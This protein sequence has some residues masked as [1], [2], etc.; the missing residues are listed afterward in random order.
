MLT[1][2]ITYLLVTVVTCC[3]V[4][5]QQQHNF[6]NIQAKIMQAKTKVKN[7]DQKYKPNTCKRYMATNKT[8]NYKP[9]I[10]CT[11]IGSRAVSRG[12]GSG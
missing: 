5:K 12:G 9:Q 11:C 7:T 8:H 6:K 10:M 4:Y 2:L 1:Y 3:S